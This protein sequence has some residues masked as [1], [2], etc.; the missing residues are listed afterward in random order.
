M[1]ANKKVKNKDVPLAV[2]SSPHST[3]ENTVIA[4]DDTIY[5]ELSKF[6]TKNNH[7]D[8][9]H[10]DGHIRSGRDLFVTDD[11]DFL[12]CKK[13]L[14]EKFGIQIKTSIEVAEMFKD[15]AVT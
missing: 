11:N 4:A 14:F 7:G 5:P 13:E 9:M 12:S 15:D 6:M 2:S 3:I 8:A 10:L 1:I